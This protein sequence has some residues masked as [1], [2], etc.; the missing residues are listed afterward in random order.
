MNN[1]SEFELL[2]LQQE[3][4]N[5][6]LAIIVAVIT[7]LSVALIYWDYKHRKNKERAEK[8]IQIAEEFAK[9]VIA[10][11]SLIENV[12]ECFEINK[13]VSK[14]S[15]IRFTDFDIDELNELFEE[16]DISKYQEI[17]NNNK[18][19]PINNNDINIKALII[20]TLNRLEYMCMYISTKVAD[21]KYIYNSLHQQFFKTLTLLYFEISLI[22]IN[23]KDKYYTNIISVYNLWKKKYIKAEKKENRFKQK[24]KKLKRKLSLPSPKI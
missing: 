15:F 20:D 2:T 14:V 9:D 1:M 21:E 10:P 23:N 11:L 17:L 7:F 3:N 24:Q 6:I 18:T 8:S 13:I 12:F 5:F 22:N 19:I 4:K 16:T